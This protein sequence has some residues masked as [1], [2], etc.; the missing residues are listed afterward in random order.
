M[1]KSVGISLIA[2]IS[3]LGIQGSYAA[4]AST[5]SHQSL[6]QLPVMQDSFLSAARRF[7]NPLLINEPIKEN[8]AELITPHFIT[9][10]NKQNETLLQI[11]FTKTGTLEPGDAFFEDGNFYD[12][13]IFEGQVG[14]IIKLNLTSEDFNTRLLLF[15]SSKESIT[16]SYNNNDNT[17]SELAWELSR[18]T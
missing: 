8:T 1:L 10:R 7:G 14:Q 9:S 18:W 6:T 3:T 4:K 2:M 11:P 17:S 12:V 13:Y 5:T 15:N 16:S